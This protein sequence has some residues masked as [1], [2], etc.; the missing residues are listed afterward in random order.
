MSTFAKYSYADAKYSYAEPISGF[1]PD[2]Q[3]AYNQ[4]I[5]GKNLFITGPGG[6]GKT[7]L[8]KSMVEYLKERKIQY[9]ICAMTGCA[10]TLL[11]YGATTLHSWSGIKI[12]NGPSSNIK[13]KVMRNKFSV[14][15][16]KKVK[17]LFVDEV[18]MMS[19]KV[20]DILEWLGRNIRHNSLLPFG[21]IQVIFTGDFY[22]LPPIETPGDEDSGAFCFESSRWNQ[23]FSLDCQIQLT[24]IFRQTDDV[25]KG[26]LNQIRCGTLDP[27]SSEILFRHVNR[28]MPD[29]PEFMPTKVY[30]VRASADYINKLFY[31]KIKEPEMVYEFEKKRNAKTHLDDGYPISPDI[32]DFVEKMPAE[33]I[34]I[35]HDMLINNSNRNPVLRLKVGAKVMC[36]INIDVEKGICNGA[37]G[38]VLRFMDD[39]EGKMYPFVRF[40]NGIEMLIQRHWMQSENY[41]PICAGQVPL[42]LAWA[43][44]IHK[45]QG[46]TLS[47]AEMDIGNS[48]FEY[49]QTY[50]ALSRVKNLEGL[51]LTG[52]NPQ[53]IKA[54]PKV[55]EYYDKLPKRNLDAIET[56]TPLKEPTLT[57]ES[58]ESKELEEE[59]YETTPATT[60][61]IFL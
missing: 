7:F 28:P 42:T 6:A 31:S 58:K 4:F 3:Y 37:Q 34:E 9:S 18:S 52:F 17:V 44:T 27:A 35:E 38:V 15:N 60:K 43:V 45:I 30:A 55:K 32:I 23:T 40:T 49:G 57:Q 10:A 47:Y 14:A 2:Q 13:Q 61:K 51:Y 39:G 21:G 12:A 1:S 11:G 33:E 54:H 5:R 25:Y 22:Q 8:V 59:S 26:I 19:K 20:F 36:L 48:I 41:P 56:P 46:A 50:V 53:K 16:W 29:N 24:S